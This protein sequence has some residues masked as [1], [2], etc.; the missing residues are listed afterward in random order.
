MPQFV[1][2]DDERAS[3]WKNRLRLV[4]STALTPA[5]YQDLN[6]QKALRKAPP[7]LR[8]ANAAGGG[9]R[10]G[11]R[12]SCPECSSS[13]S[14]SNVTDENRLTIQG[15]RRKLELDKGSWYRQE[16]GLP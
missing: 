3:M 5:E 15:E 11:P 12:R 4:G 6:A 1:R 10:Y 8:T 7:R 2:K 13:T 9:M 14:K 16:R